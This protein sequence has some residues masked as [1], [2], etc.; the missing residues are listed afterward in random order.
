M[1]SFLYVFVR[2]VGLT[3]GDIKK[4]FVS[5]ALGCGINPESAIKIGM[6]PEIPRERLLPLG[7]SSLGG[8]EM[9]LLDCNLLEEVRKVS[10][11]ITYREM[12]EDA[13]LMNILQGA[14]FIP[15]TDPEFLKV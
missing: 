15:H 4:V 2:S 13:E 3:F 5:G 9:I 8:A 10:S 12:N 11:M 6:L 7:N 1:F 14:I